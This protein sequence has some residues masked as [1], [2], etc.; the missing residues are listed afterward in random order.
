MKKMNGLKKGFFLVLLFTSFNTFSQVNIKDSSIF[1][2]MFYGCYAYQVPGGDMADRFGNN[3]DIG[4]G[5]QIKLKSNW[6]LGTEFNYLWGSKVKNGDEIL[7]NVLT[8]DGNL[9]NIGGMYAIF[10]L[11]ERGYTITG[12]VG[13]VIPV[14]SPNPNS[15]IYFR[16]GVGYMQHWI[17]IQVQEQE[18]VPWMDD[19]YAKGYDRLSSGLT[20][21]EFIGY[22]FLGNT[23]IFNFYAGFEFVQAWTKNRRDVNFDTG[24]KDDK[25]RFDILT[26]FKIG[27]VIPL[28]KRTPSDYYFY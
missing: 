17:R 6:L 28:Y 16:A 23:R 26:G 19:D 18:S 1:T 8:S 27:W 10:D 24:E 14:L 15:G 4:A 13:K 9:I 21:N 25:L 3:S 5:F 20:I 2:P 12:Y 22:L 7:K 11:F